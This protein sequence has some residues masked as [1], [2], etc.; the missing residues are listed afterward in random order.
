MQAVNLR[1]LEIG[2]PNQPI[3]VFPI[4]DGELYS[5][6]LNTFLGTEPVILRNLGLRY[7]IK[8]EELTTW[9][10]GEMRHVGV[11]AVGGRGYIF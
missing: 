8:T 3:S 7:A 4:S 1:W 11:F 10:N 9:L 2:L 6:T 5:A